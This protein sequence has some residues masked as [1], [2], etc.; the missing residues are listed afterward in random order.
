MF[1]VGSVDSYGAVSGDSPS[2][3]LSL[4]PY[5][6]YVDDSGSGGVQGDPPGTTGGGMNPSQLIQVNNLA[7]TLSNAGLS[8]FS[9]LSGKTPTVVS[10]SGVINSQ[11][12]QSQTLL[13][14]GVVVIAAI[15]LLR[16]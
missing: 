9:T 10:P 16:K 3:V 11:T 14:L 4:P 2:S 5:P 8:W 13:I 7:A 12:Q 6:L 15:L 1:S